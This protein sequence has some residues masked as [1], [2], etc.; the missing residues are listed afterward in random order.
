MRRGSTVVLGFSGCLIAL[1]AWQLGAAG[2]DAHS[3]VPPL[4]LT[5][6]ALGGMMASSA[7]WAS[8]GQILT[9]TGAGLGLA[10]VVGVVAG[11]LIGTS[12]VLTDATRVPLE[13][14]KPIHPIVILPIAVMVFGPNHTMGTFLIFYGCV[15]PITYQTAAGVRETDPVAVETARS[16]GLGRVETM[17]RLVFPSTAA[18][19]GTAIRIVLPEALML[20]V[21]AGLVGGGPGLGQD[22]FRTRSANDFAAMYGVVIVLGLLGLLTMTIGQAIE[23]RVLHWHPSY[24]N[25]AV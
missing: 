13:F 17:L 19:I 14:L 15:I 3:A 18:F 12:R 1:L 24:R 11:L 10:V 23:R 5:M 16:F 21:L 2:G 4:P 8:V 20:A 7:F 25:E 6:Q 22:I 9:M